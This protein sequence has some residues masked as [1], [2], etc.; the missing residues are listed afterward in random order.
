[1]TLI[2][3]FHLDSVK[4]NLHAKYICQKLFSSKVIVRMHTYDQLLYTD[5][6]NCMHIDLRG[7]E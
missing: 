7:L 1:M 4:M 3:E 2:L 5:L 6:L